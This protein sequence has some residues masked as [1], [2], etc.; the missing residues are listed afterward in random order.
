MLIF[1]EAAASG[2]GDWSPVV[3]AVASIGFAAWMASYLMTKYIPGRDAEHAKTI[4]TVSAAHEATIR[5]VVTDFRTDLQSE[6]TARAA[7]SQRIAAAIEN[8]CRFISDGSCS[9]SKS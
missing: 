5:Q 6:R 2:V 8:S 3:S 9:R 7:D 1:A 4:E